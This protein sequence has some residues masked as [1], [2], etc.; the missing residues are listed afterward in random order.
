MTWADWFGTVVYA[1]VA[2]GVG[3]LAVRAAR[4]E[5]GAVLYS[6][7][8]YYLTGQLMLCAL[9]LATAFVPLT[10]R[11]LALGVLV[12]LAAWWTTGFVRRGLGQRIL[13]A[14]PGAGLFLLLTLLC[15]P[16]AFVLVHDTPVL[17]W[18][19]RSIW[20]FHG[21]ALALDGGVTR[22]FFGNPLYGWSHLDYP[23]LLPAQAAWLATLTGEWNDYACRAFLGVNLA[24][25]FALLTAVFRARRM[26]WWLA[27]GAGVF[28]L[29]RQTEG[30][31]NG[32]AD[33]HYALA[34]ALALM[35]LCTPRGGAR[36][37][38]IALLLGYAAALKNEAFLYAAL[39]A[40]GTAA[41]Y[42]LRRRGRVV[43]RP[44]RLGVWIGL[45]GLLP[46]ALWLGFRS[47]AYVRPAD[48]AL[49]PNWGDLGRI[50]ALLGERGVA[51][52]RGLR[53]CYIES[54]VPVLLA[55]LGVLAVL[56]TS[57]ARRGRAGVRL[58]S[59]DAALLLAFPALNVLIFAMF[60][61][62]PYDLGWHMGTAAGRLT[63]LPELLLAF[64]VA[65]G[66][67]VLCGDDEDDG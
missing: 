59:G 16:F 51:A 20:F 44:A 24:A 57:A 36:P 35:L 25:W 5:G 28:I 38:L 42:A 58:G 14:L 2:L 47:L 54:G 18:D 55:V 19:A 53:A 17:E 48:A 61:F 12:V 1:V 52:A 33:N 11:H 27:G 34:L 41:W 56:R 30:Y 66:A 22:A 6:W 31:V 45:T 64:A 21:K 40:A 32:Y 4:P 29:A 50:G 10:L 9:T 63:F 23:L 39:I 65:D 37:A 15:F 7:P 8:V 46:G 13:A 3:H 26:P 60:L 67:G 43:S 49:I 62:T